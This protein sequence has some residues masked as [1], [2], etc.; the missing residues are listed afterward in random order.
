V[1]CAVVGLVG[2]E[3]DPEPLGAIPE[4]VV[5]PSPLVSDRL[6]SLDIFAVW[7]C[8]WD[9]SEWQWGDVKSSCVEC[10]VGCSW[11]TCM[12]K[13][14][15]HLSHNE[16]VQ[17]DFTSVCPNWM[18]GSFRSG[19]PHE[20][21]NNLAWIEKKRETDGMVRWRDFRGTQT[22]KDH[23]GCNE[24]RC[25]ANDIRELIR[26]SV[27]AQSNCSCF[28]HRTGPYDSSSFESERTSIYHS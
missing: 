13:W 18:N 12:Y 15:Y 27:H 28:Q 4:E 7:C 8:I 11:Q 21:P 14:R 5:T 17:A 9:V 19:R 10:D 20:C 2:T 25:I 26:P 1:G 23:S 3:S 22:T 6:N 24:E 16:H